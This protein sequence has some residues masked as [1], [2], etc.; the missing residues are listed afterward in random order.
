MQREALP[1][2][3]ESRQETR[4][5]EADTGSRVTRRRVTRGK[6]PSD[7]SWGNPIR[8][9]AARLAAS[10]EVPRIWAVDYYSCQLSRTNEIAA[11]FARSR[12]SG[13]NG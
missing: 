13:K 1:P 4:G 11:I 5:D 9:H 7:V 8:N 6:G 10:R 3:R 12:C 2:Q